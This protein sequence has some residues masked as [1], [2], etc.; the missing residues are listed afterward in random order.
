MPG[1]IARM[2][3]RHRTTV[4]VDP[5]ETGVP[6]QRGYIVYHPRYRAWLIR[7]GITTQAVAS[8]LPGEIVCGHP[9][10]HVVRV[11]LGQGTGCRVVFLKREHTIGLRVRV[12]NRLAGFGP[13]SRAE[14]EALILRQ[15]EQAGLPGPQ[16][17]AFGEDEQGHGF[18]LVDQVSGAEELRTILAQHPLST[19]DR[20]RLMES[21]GR[22]LAELHAA[23]FSTPDLAAKHVLINPETFAVT[24]LDW[25][26][27]RQGPIPRL[28]DRIR[29][30]AGLSASLTEHLASP[31]DRLRFLWAYRRVLHA[32]GHNDSG[33]RRLRFRTL[34]RLVETQTSRLRHRSS[35]RDQRT[36]SA[37]PQRL[38]WLDGEK[39]CIVPEMQDIWPHPVSG[40]PFYREDDPFSG[41]TCPEEWLTFADNT[42]AVLQRFQSVAPLARWAAV[43]RERPWRSPAASQARILFHL[44][45]YGIDGPRLLGF[46]QRL[47]SHARADSFIVYAPLADSQSLFDRL[48][49]LPAHSEERRTFLREVGTMLRKLHDS[50][51]RFGTI[52]PGDA[53]FL[54]SHTRPLQL[55]V[56]APTSIRLVKRIRDRDRLTDFVQLCRV[57]LP[58]FS[59]TDYVRIAHGYAPF[60]RDVRQFRKRL[61]AGVI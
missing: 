27:S 61:L 45:R 58:G 47:R 33:T 57:V 48:D 12:Q 38:L 17:L 36:S 21:I 35:A 60:G 53:V 43:L 3:L 7:C 41:T 44:A 42:R 10:R 6:A 9:D 25:Q 18:L 56:D 4:P 49:D 31:A 19:S 14:R 32:S 15:L 11:E 16:W 13:V 24:L 20:R 37:S 5:V 40:A 59:R 22:T 52:H 55:S 51:C 1:S 8:T 54:A 34:A 28:T 23:G 26:S 39:A 50:R 2:I 30:L 46:G 29:Q